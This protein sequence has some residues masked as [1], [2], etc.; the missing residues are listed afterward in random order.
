[1]SILFTEADIGSMTIPNRMIRAASHEG[2]ADSRGRPTD[3]QFEFYKGFVEGGIGLI[4]TGYAGIMQSGKSA[5]YHMTMIDS[6]NLIS[7]HKRL[8]DGIHQLG[9]KI[10]LQ[11]AHCGRQTWSKVTGEPLQAPSAMPCG[12]Y[13][14][15]PKEMSEGEI[16]TVIENFAKA[17]L[18]AKE[19]GYDGVQI[20]AAH[21]YLLST[22]LSCYSN[23]RED[24]WGGGME[25]RFRIVGDT[26]RAV[27]EA[28]GKD[29][30]VLI[31]INT[32]ENTPSG[33]KPEECIQFAMMAAGTGCCDAIELSCGTNEDGFVMTRGKFPTDAIFKYMRPYC[34]YHPAVKFLLKTFV[35]PFKKIRQPPFAEGYNLETAAR[36]KKVI[37][38]PVITVGGIRS[39]RFMEMAID[40]GKT[41]F[42]S[43]AR[44]L[45][46]EPDLANKFK[47]GVSEV[48]LCDNCNECVVASDT[49]PIQCYKKKT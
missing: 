41:D 46:R 35:V 13:Q 27:K 43:M 9:G 4:I 1:M 48:A 31:K 47:A 30:P 24:R 18:R 45:I 21:G 7:H 36:V 19:S 8:V 44:P 32:F 22:F 39:K 3:E 28:V 37:S 42:I 49:K 16:Y 6:D 17:A 5:L 38:L 11:I 10:V 20:H 14:E 29:Y 23:K 12:F 40:E 34:E 26:L 2:L 15:M 33:I 25:N